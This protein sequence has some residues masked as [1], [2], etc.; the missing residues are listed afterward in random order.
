MRQRGFSLI[1]LMMVFVVVGIVL[2]VGLPTFSAF[3]R[4]MKERQ[5]RE[6]LR[7]NLRNARQAAVTRH[8]PVVVAFG[9]GGQTTG[10]TRYVVLVD[11]NGD[12]TRQTTES[13]RDYVLPKNCQLGMSGFQPCDSLIFDLSGALW[14]GTRGGEFIISGATTSDTLALSATGMVYEP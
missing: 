11:V 6:E 13:A 1:E 8:C 10:I 9:T 7:Q 2:A 4:T 12:R 3:T 14:P 5:A